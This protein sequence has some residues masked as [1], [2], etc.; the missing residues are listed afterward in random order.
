MVLKRLPL[1]TSTKAPSPLFRE[2]TPVEDKSAAAARAATSTVVVGQSTSGRLQVPSAERGAYIRWYGSVLGPGKR[3][4]T[5]GD[6][7]ISTT[8]AVYERFK[9]AQSRVR[10]LIAQRGTR[11]LLANYGPG[12]WKLWRESDADGLAAFD[13]VVTG[14]GPNRDPNAASVTVLPRAFADWFLNRLQEER[15]QLGVPP[16]TA[17][18]N[19]VR[20]G[21]TSS[22]KHTLLGFN[23][24]QSTSSFFVPPAA[25]NDAPVIPGVAAG[26]RGFITGGGGGDAVDTD[27]GGYDVEE[28]ERRA[29]IRN[30]VVLAGA[31]A[32][33]GVV[34]GHLLKKSK[35]WGALIGVGAGV[36]L[37]MVLPTRLES[38]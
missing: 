14:N 35:G 34:T 17:V 16:M 2:T 37:G 5:A 6:G 11:N 36:F 3:P 10:A 1:R 19:V 9:K 4:T 24:T 30:T 22:E 28:E 31:G 8:T 21:L 26:A 13:K 23:I 12:A 15:E 33:A 32:G 27:D 29:R 18:N 38:F 25:S 7:T 20:R